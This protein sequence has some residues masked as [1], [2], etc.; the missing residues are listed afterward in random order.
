VY[1]KGI[2]V[3]DS[4]SHAHPPD[5][6]PVALGSAGRRTK[7]KATLPRPQADLDSTRE[8]QAIAYRLA[9]W[10]FPWDTTRSLEFALFR[11]F[12]SPRIGGLL[13]ATAE[14]EARP[15]KRYDDTDLI[16]SELLEHGYDSERGRRAIA[17]MNEIHG[18]FRIANDDFV[19][20]LSTFV[21][22][23]IRWNSR[24][25]W[26]PMTDG[27]R[28]GWFH[29]WLEVG[30]RMGIR[31]LPER[32]DDLECFNRDYER[33]SYRHTEAGRKVGEATRSLFASWFPGPARPMVRRAIAAL[34]DDPVREAFGFSN[35]P[36]WLR[37]TVETAL[38]LRARFL[39]WLPPRR[40]PRLRTAL[41]R[42]A[43][44]QGYRIEGLG[45][46]PGGT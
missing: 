42:S 27:E 8:C 4:A 29:F 45:P 7:E 25:G 34:L 21:F 37:K 46:P 44:P 5:N 16:V 32:Y 31:D 18:R 19:Y 40:R 30:R 20:V 23:P 13:H 2:D 43:Y 17:R 1:S 36:N 35:P 24:F 12:A 15:Q 3:L 28:L 33:S 22:E 14:F 26:R 11:T 39:R 38:H 9:C 10:D 6:G 41:P